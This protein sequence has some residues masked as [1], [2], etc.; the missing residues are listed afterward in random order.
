MP[1]CFERK[2]VPASWHGLDVDTTEELAEGENAKIVAA[3]Y[4]PRYIG[5]S[6]RCIYHLTSKY[7]V[8]EVKVKRMVGGK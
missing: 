4:K 6:R 1:T 2:T 8:H 7:L 5:L 3:A